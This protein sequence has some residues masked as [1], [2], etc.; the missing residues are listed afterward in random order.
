MIREKILKAF[1]K[2]DDF[3]LPS[4]GLIDD[5]EMQILNFEVDEK[6]ADNR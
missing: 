5:A 1:P 4:K 2:L 6:K 3:L